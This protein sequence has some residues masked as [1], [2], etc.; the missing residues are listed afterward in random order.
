ML[1]VFKVTETS[2]ANV[3]RGEKLLEIFKLTLMTCMIIRAYFCSKIF[4][5]AELFLQ[6]KINMK[7]AFSLELTYQTMFEDLTKKQSIKLDVLS[8]ATP[9]LL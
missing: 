5:C 6:K 2:D 1:L 4:H 8:G 3:K 9:Y 7:Y